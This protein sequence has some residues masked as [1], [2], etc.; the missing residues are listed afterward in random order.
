MIKIL[1]IK[2][3]HKNCFLAFGRHIGKI[4][5]CCTETLENSKNS[6]PIQ[7]HAIILVH[8]LHPFVLIVPVK[9]CVGC[10]CI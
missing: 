7:A 3:F 2:R 10:N 8:A 1:E 6:N 4:Y 5:L 9:N